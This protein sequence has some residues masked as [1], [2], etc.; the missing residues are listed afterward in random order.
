M[1]RVTHDKVQQC[2]MT[3]AGASLREH[4]SNLRDNLNELLNAPE[5]WSTFLSDRGLTSP[6]EERVLRQIRLRAL[7]SKC[8]G[9]DLFVDPAWDILLDLYS[10]YLGGRRISVSSACIASQAPTTTG[11]RWI[12]VLESRGMI[13][14]KRDS[15]DGRRVYVSLTE[16]AIGAMKRYFELSAQYSHYR[17]IHS[18]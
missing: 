3:A 9:D 8:F 18:E 15:C 5:E 2:S 13:E 7:R 17:I 14:R 4:L 12:T 16:K 6:G 1:S 10:A 11:L